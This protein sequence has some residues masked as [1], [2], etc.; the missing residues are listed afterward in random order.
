MPVCAVSSYDAIRRC[1]YVIHGH[2]LVV[3]SLPTLE[4]TVER[5]FCSIFKHESCILRSKARRLPSLR[6]YIR[7]VPK[8][9][10]VVLHSLLA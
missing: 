10:L 2:R 1:E 9:S 5:H 3:H 8:P 7:R 4:V 6:V